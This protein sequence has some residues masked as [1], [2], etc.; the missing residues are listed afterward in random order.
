MFIPKQQQ[1]RTSGMN[2]I[3]YPESDERPI[4]LI[5]NRWVEIDSQLIWAVYLLDVLRACFA[6]KENVYVGANLMMYFDESDLN[7]VVAPDIFFVQGIGKKLRNAYK[8]WEEGQIPHLVI[9]LL[10]KS[11]FFID[12]GMK[13][14]LYA[15]LGVKEYI[16]LDPEFLHIK[17]AILGYKLVDDYYQQIP[18]RQQENDTWVLAS[19][20]LGLEFQLQGKV[21]RLVEP[22]TGTI[23]LPYAEEAPARR[24]A[25][26]R[27][28]ELGELVRQLREGK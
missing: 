7:A 11:S 24:A 19:Q 23:L 13:R 1:Q 12:K 26:A 9:E 27:V 6:E 4:S 20:V 17:P 8:V 18:I 14:G 3:E 22:A 2:P 16:L 10:S 28:A 5:S 25:E 21:L 15:Y